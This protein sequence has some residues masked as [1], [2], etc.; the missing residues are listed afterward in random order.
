MVLWHYCTTH[1][2]SSPR[3]S[4]LCSVVVV[5]SSSGESTAQYGYAMLCHAR[6][7]H[8]QISACSPAPTGHLLPTLPI[9]ARM[10]S[11]QL[12]REGQGRQ[13]EVTPLTCRSQ[14]FKADPLSYM[15][16]RHFHLHLLLSIP[17]GTKRAIA[18]TIT[19]TLIFRPL[20]PLL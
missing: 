14:L 19:S 7:L 2:A 13:G 9:C 18:P 12:E 11:V 20:R 10:C 8:L 1:H 4:P 17:R 16:S 5:H 6:T 3:A 15:K